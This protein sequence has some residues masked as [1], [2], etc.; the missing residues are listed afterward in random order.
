MEDAA[1]NA[2]AKKP[3]KKRKATKRKAAKATKRKS[4]KATAKK[5][6]KRKKA[7][8]QAG[9]RASIISV[10][11]NLKTSLSGS[12]MSPEQVGFRILGEA[13]PIRHLVIR[14]SSTTPLPG[15]AFYQVV[16]QRHRMKRIFPI[17]LPCRVTPDRER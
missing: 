6:T 11:G 1:V 4:A 12:D 15:P 7:S 17:A 9:I 3:A 2:E 14:L 16:R 5:A 8:K 13:N 10:P